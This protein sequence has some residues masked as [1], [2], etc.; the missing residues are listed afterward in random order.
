MK[1]IKFLSLLI[2]SIGFAAPAS[3]QSL[4][5]VTVMPRNV[6]T[7]DDLTAEAFSSPEV[8]NIG[9]T[10]TTTTLNLP[11]VTAAYTGTAIPAPVTVRGFLTA[12]D[13][14]FGSPSKV[15][16]SAMNTSIITLAVSTVK[17]YDFVATVD[18]STVNANINIG[19]TSENAAT[20]LRIGATSK[21]NL[22]FAFPHPGAATMKWVKIQPKKANSTEYEEV[23]ALM[24]QQP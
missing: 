9:R 3:A 4:R 5:M 11:F 15:Y 14:T 21:D 10:G 6:I 13:V 8:T 1:I 12:G 17:T 20:G 19:A 23:Y 16:D 24:L 18:F 2:L 22:G 7:V